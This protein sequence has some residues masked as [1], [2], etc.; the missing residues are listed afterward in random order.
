MIEFWKWLRSFADNQVC[1]RHGGGQKCP[2]CQRWTWQMT[3]EPSW[4]EEFDYYVMHCNVCGENSR[5]IDT[6]FMGL[7]ICIDNKETSNVISQN[8]S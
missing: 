3:P 2:N 1:K 7:M 4:T 6:G 8:R 5:W